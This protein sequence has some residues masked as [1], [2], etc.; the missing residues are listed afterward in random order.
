LGFSF[1][2]VTKR[3]VVGENDD[4]LVKTCFGLVMNFDRRVMAGAGRL[5]RSLA[6]D[7]GGRLR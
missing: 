4:I 6:I 5:A 2:I 1:G 3:P 7:A